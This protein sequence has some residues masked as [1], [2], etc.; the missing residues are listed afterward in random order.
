M[1]K[2]ILTSLFLFGAVAAI[3]PAHAMYAEVFPL[4]KKMEKPL[5]MLEQ[6]EKVVGTAI[7]INSVF[8]LDDK[9]QLKEFGK[10]VESTAE[11]LEYKV[12]QLQT[13]ETGTIDVTDNKVRIKYESVGKPEQIKEFKKPK[14]LV[15][16]ANFERW[17][18]V[19]FEALKK[20][21]TTVID[22]L[23]WDRMETLKFKVTYLGLIEENGK[24]QHQFKMNIDNFLLASFISPIRIAM[25]ED[26]S[27]IQRFQGRLG[28]KLKVG[29]EFKS[30]DGD[31]IYYY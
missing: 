28:V 4:D 26:M 18:K 6:T 2:I 16:P 10:I 8:K 25:S 20:E 14:V 12:T 11:I 24:K 13:N 27:K 1:K 23:I 3:T 30:F 17:L 19:N 21:K 31:V 15:A 9:P 22:F 29:S 7:E 5:F